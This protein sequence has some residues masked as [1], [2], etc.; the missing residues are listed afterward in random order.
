MMFLIRVAG[1]AM[2]GLF[3][4]Q[5]FGLQAACSSSSNCT[6]LGFLFEQV[7]IMSHSPALTRVF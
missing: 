1:M 4:G 7:W 3:V 2:A 6:G 5:T